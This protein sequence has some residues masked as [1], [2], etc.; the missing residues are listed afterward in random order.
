MSRS[1]FTLSVPRTI[2]TA[3]K[4]MQQNKMVSFGTTT[5]H[6][7]GGSGSGSSAP[8]PAPAP[9]GFSFASSSS[10]APAPAPGGFSF[11]SSSSTA[12]APAPGGFS[13]GSSSFS[14]APAPG[15]GIFGSP[16]P[17]PSTGFGSVAPAPASSGSFFGGGAFGSPAPGGIFGT[18]APAPFGASTQQQ[19]QPVVPAQAAMQAH[20]T[21]SALQEEQRVTKA[22][23][24][25]Q[26]AYGGMAPA[27]ETKSAPFTSIV[28]NA[29]TSQ[30]RQEQLV[31]GI[32]V[33]GT[34]PPIAPPKP[35]QI[36]ES[37]WL[38]AVVRNPDNANLMPIPLV[39][40]TALLA[41]SMSHQEQVN[42]HMGQLASIQEARD[43]LREHY[44]GTC[45][46]LNSIERTY[47][48][49]R[50]KLL[51]VMKKVELIRCL[52]HPLQQ[53]E[54]VVMK[55][56]KQLVDQVAHLQR[57]L[58]DWMDNAARSQQPLR[59][60][61]VTDMP[62]PEQLKTVL[63]QH[64][65]ALAQLTSTVQRDLHDLDLI[66]KRVESKVTVPRPQS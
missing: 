22:L 19:Q 41:R 23:E 44:E 60:P 46:Q 37:D 6:T 5:V 12:P 33:D 47:T 17:G 11:A 53:D 29:S 66:Q 61:H 9:G 64:R 39:G 48:H 2:H 8:T 30:M 35:T 51:S 40:A 1:L 56:L 20:L 3:E 21:A 38:T 36:S 49:L 62:D 31:R 14:N 55:K 24:N 54:I 7:I 34:T 25:I 50:M 43:N 28:Y 57:T 65:N 13:F 58:N 52:H 42:S 27:T 26:L 45:A 15:G 4:A 32:G 10:T 18:A 16:A 59:R 63:I